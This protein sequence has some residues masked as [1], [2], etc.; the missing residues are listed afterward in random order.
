MSFEKNIWNHDFKAL[1]RKVFSLQK[2]L[3]KNKSKSFLSA[4]KPRELMQA[5]R[6][7]SYLAKTFEVVFV[8]KRR[9]CCCC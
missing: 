8:W 1:L 7:L 3:R 6:N 2:P 9:D 5:N 4:D